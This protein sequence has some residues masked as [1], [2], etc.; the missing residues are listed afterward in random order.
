MLA[1]STPYV[2]SRPFFDYGPSLN[3]QPI[4]VMALIN[5]WIELRSDA[6]KIAKLGRRPLPSRTDSIGAW[7]SAL[8]S[9][10]TPSHLI[11]S[12]GS[13]VLGPLVSLLCRAL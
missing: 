5:N 3:C 11:P 6:F 8:V 12:I 1:A 10:V 9:F 4:I 13:I 7:L 2:I